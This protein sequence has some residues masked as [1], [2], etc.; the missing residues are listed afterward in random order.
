M[1]RAPCPIIFTT[2]IPSLSL[3]LTLT[4]KSKIFE[5]MAGGVLEFED[6]FPIMADKLGEE[7]FMV[8]LCN[9]FRLLMDESKGLITF[10][11]LKRNACFLGL[12][13]LSDEEMMEMVREGD[14]D[15]DGGLNQMEFCVLM[16]R[17]SPALMEGGQRWLEEAL[18]QE[19]EEFVR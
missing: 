18:F 16:V 6:F 1:A 7:K 4:Y 8:E 13:C 12:E 9:G 2:A 3:S 15:G 17:L 5:A 10:E 14:S 19:L 11:S